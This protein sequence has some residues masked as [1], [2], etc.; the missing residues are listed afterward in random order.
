MQRNKSSKCIFLSDFNIFVFVL[1]SVRP[2]H[3]GRCYHWDFLPP[4]RCLL[5][6]CGSTHL[7]STL[8]VC[9]LLFDAL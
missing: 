1:G 4:S 7:L 6:T 2:A 8:S 3:G 5:P 9:Y